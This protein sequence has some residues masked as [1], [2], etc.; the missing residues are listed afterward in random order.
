MTKTSTTPKS[1]TQ[2]SPRVRIQIGK[3]TALGPGKVE[4]LQA[5]DTRGSISGAARDMGM[6]YRHAWILV[7]AM[8]AA[9]TSDLVVTSTGG[10]GGGGAKVT[11]LGFE[12][13]KRFRTMEDKAAK[14]VE[15]E[16]LAFAKLLKDPSGDA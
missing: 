4:L 8:N 16:A 13:M 12:V 9:F 1:A 7:D 10:K 3:A 5:I 15:A 6:S 11:E 14:S 2:K